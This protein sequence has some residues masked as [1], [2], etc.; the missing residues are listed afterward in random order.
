MSTSI[1]LAP[2]P[3]SPEA[4]AHEKFAR[5]FKH[6]LHMDRDF[7]KSLAR[8]MLAYT[9]RTAV[10]PS[11]VHADKFLT[12]L[13]V[14]YVNDD[15]IGEKLMPV[16]SVSSRSDKFLKHDKRNLLNGP[17]DLSSPRARA[18]E[19]EL[20]FTEDNYSVT[21]YH[22]QAYV[23]K[24][25]EANADETYME[26]VNMTES[27]TEVLA[28]KREL[29]YSALLGVAGSYG[30]NTASLASAEWN[31]VVTPNNDPLPTIQTINASLW[32]GGGRTK[33]V[34][35][36]TQKVLNALINNTAIRGL[37]QYTT[38]GLATRQQI[39]AF[40]GLDDLYVTNARYDSANIGQTASYTTIWP[41]VFL[42]ARVMTNPSRHTAG[43][44]ATF[45]WTPGSATSQWFDPEPG[46]LG[47]TYT[48]VAF[49]ED[50]KLIA[51][52]DTSYLLTNVA[53]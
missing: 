52:T 23:D 3:K 28:L 27:L 47:G 32:A 43:L 34:G 19:I 35:A 38:G 7:R 50:L 39:A 16:V 31:E 1:A 25:T 22:M 15:F 46:N 20:T 17:S 40:M 8:N 36:T 48:K 2:E 53:L 42:I 6:K 49:S 44:G 26:L 45:R 14:G 41:D 29:R 4:S 12:Q 24:M 11:T 10:T 21:D 51:P 30:S 37:F 9:Q 13:S 18:N 5:S 33:L